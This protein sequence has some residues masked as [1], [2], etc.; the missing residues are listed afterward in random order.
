MTSL[1]ILVIIIVILSLR[2]KGKKEYQKALDIIS[3]IMLMLEV[4][5]MLWVIIFRSGEVHLIRFDWCN[6]VCL[7]MP[8]AIL[9]RLDYYIPFYKGAAFWGGM[10]VLAYPLWVFYDYGGIHIMAIQ[11]MISHGLMV[12]VSFLLILSKESAGIKKE[13]TRIL[14]GFMMMVAIAAI[15]SSITGDNYMALRSAER[16]PL[17]RFIPHPY[18]LLFMLGIEFIGLCL[19][20]YLSCFI[21]RKFGAKDEIL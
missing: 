11:S 7:L 1:M 15:G 4:F 17:V 20:D 5:R 18:Y 6:Q 19:V 2:K 13:W 21:Y 3:I 12:L 10:G 16:L 8:I 14:T 9:L